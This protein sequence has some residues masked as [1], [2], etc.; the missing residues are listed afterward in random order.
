[1]HENYL[2]K[3]YSFGGDSERVLVGRNVGDKNVYDQEM[4]VVPFVDSDAGVNIYKGDIGHT[5]DFRDSSYTNGISDMNS[6]SLEDFE[7]NAVLI[8][9]DILQKT[10]Q[11]NVKKTATNLYG[12][13]ILDNV[14]NDGNR[15]YIQRYPK[16]R[17]TVYGSGNSYV[18]KVDLKVDTIG[19]TNGEYEII[20]DP[21]SAVSFNLYSQ[22][23]IQ[24][25]NCIDF[26]YT[27]KK[28][29]VDLS[30]RIE[31]LENLLMGIDSIESLKNDIS[32]LYDLYDGNMSVDTATL[33][34]LID[35]NAKKLNTIMNGGKDLKLQYDT[36][37]LQPGQGIGMTKTLNKVVIS[38][39]DKYAVNT[40]IDGKYDNN[41]EVTDQNPIK[42]ADPAKIC[43]IQL[44]PGE[45]FAVIYL[46]DTGDSTSN[47]YINID[48]SE[49]NWSVGQSMKIFFTCSDNGSLRFDS[50]T[51]DTHGLI[52]KP[53]SNTTLDISGGEIEG[54]DLIEIICIADN[55]FIYI[56]K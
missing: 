23:L 20:K 46:E 21:N 2:N 49:Y 32:K 28:Q 7:F 9:Y 22:S 54:N 11:S 31:T 34:G 50:T 36:D 35:A 8:Y 13:L 3:N 29:I 6:K 38:S 45:N 25:Q 53:T 10:N 40:V 17:E 24:L 56:I 18:L 41:V 19:D 14:K 15:T 37:V 12:I 43:N 5:I 48:E 27:Q 1:M 44:R 52:I 39:E 16:K 33:L 30:Q 55:K 26:F 51:G 42:T 4:L 47:L